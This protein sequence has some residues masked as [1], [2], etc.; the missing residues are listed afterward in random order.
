MRGRRLSGLFLKTGIKVLPS[1]LQ[2]NPPQFHTLSSDYVL[3]ISEMETETF[4]TTVTSSAVTVMNIYSD[5][6]I[7]TSLA[8]GIIC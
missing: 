7:G 8:V 3:S 2:W 6:A 4:H 5:T 1:Y